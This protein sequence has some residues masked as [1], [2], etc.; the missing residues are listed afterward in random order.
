[1]STTH[2]QPLPNVYGRMAYTELGEGKKRT[3]NIQNGTN[4]IAAQMGDGDSREEFVRF[5][6]AMKRQNQG[7]ENEG[8]EVR[9][10]WAPEELSKDD[11][12]DIQRACE[13]GYLLCKEVAP[14][15]PCWVTVHTD[16]EGGCVHVHA[17][18]ANHDLETGNAIAHGTD[19]ATVKRKN[20]QLSRQ[21]GFSVVG[22]QPGAQ[23]TRW[24]DRKSEFEPGAFERMLGNRVE[25]ARNASSSMDEFRE[26]LRLRGVEL[27]EVRKVDKE[28]GEETVGWSYKAHDPLGKTKRKRR[29]RASNLADDLTKEGVEAYFE[30]K[31]RQAEA[32]KED[33]PVPVPVATVAAEPQPDSP[34]EPSFDVYSV[35]ESDV[36]QMA[37]DLQ[38]AHIDRSRESGEPFMGERYERLMEAERHPEEQLAKLQA[39]VDA[40][41]REFH[42]SKEA[43]D[44]LNHP[45]PNLLAGAWVFAKAGRDAKDPVSRMM[46]DMTAMMMRMLLQQAMEEQRRR[47]REAAERRLYESRRNM[48]DAEKRL[49]AAEKALSNEDEREEQAKRA[50]A[51]TRGQGGKAC[52]WP[53]EV[54]GRCGQAVR[55]AEK[56]KGAAR[57]CSL[58]CGLVDFRRG[59]VVPAGSEVGYP[60]D[61]QPQLR[62]VEH[63]L[64]GVLHEEARVLDDIPLE[65]LVPGCPI[66]AHRFQRAAG[67]L[68]GEH[69]AAAG[70]GQVG[71]GL[72]AVVTHRAPP[73]PPRCPRWRSRRTAA[74]SAGSRSRCSRRGC[75]RPAPPRPGRSRTATPSRCRCAS[76]RP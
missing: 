25:E 36:A 58:S 42:A 41:R 52:R 76:A 35:E 16:G 1:M 22:P 12:E 24:A 40:A 66:P 46:A 47:E 65:Y 37:G 27:N 32:Q 54:R 60:P 45:C 9:V 55:V 19:H 8:F 10:S 48:W 6:S 50:P 15:A 17:T 5:C 75:L 53:R 26:E 31:Q 30:E 20:D 59:H 18:I 21:M 62:V 74:W 67:Y 28:T 23:R 38:R 57:C 14:N 43:R 71:V 68:V 73:P 56:D 49:K 72:D 34:A 7:R 63:R 33:A 13:Y 69:H 4:R 3:E 64:V 11:P 39:E 61:V 51:G 44:A 29:R 70:L 2:I